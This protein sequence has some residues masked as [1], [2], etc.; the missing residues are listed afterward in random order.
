MEK[1]LSEIAE[2][3]NG[4]V[5]GNGDIAINDIK[6][7]DEA[8]EGDLT[9]IANPKYRGKLETTGASAIL[10]STGTEDPDKNLVIV[11]DPYVALAKI[12]GVFYPEEREPVK[13]SEDAFIA[14]GAEIAED[15][16]IYP[17]A[18][19][20]RGAKIGSGVILYPNV[21]IGND[22]AIGKDSILYPNVSVYRSCLVGK[23]VTLHAGVVVGSDGFGFV[24]PGAENLKVPQVGIVRIDDDVEIGANTTIDRGT[25][26]KT[27]IK[28]GVKIDNLVQIA[29]NVV[30]GENSVIVSQVGISGSTTLGKSV[31]LGGQV[32]VIGHLDI[33]DNVMVGAQSGV[34]EDIPPNQVVSGSPHMPHRSWLRMQALLPKLPE[35]RKT[36]NSLLK[37]V[38]E[39]EKE[40]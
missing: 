18:Y 21:F 37:R 12:L 11:K 4:T 28:K 24:N 17:G 3:L 15:V 40:K 38:E 29:H 30:I 6:G 2:L 5:V 7:I 22:A 20:G 26:G 36:M 35:M 34:P 39:L 1:K 27:W 31:I 25:L 10:V 32:G 14:D 19:I 23:R 16:T 13:I 8:K 33:G 9:F